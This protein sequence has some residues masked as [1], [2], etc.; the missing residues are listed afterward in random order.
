MEIRGATEQDVHAAIEGGE[1]LPARH[2]RTL[3]RRNLPFGGIWRGKR[4]D[5]KQ[6]EVY[7]V[8][9]GDTLIVITVIVKYF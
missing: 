5:T 2:G 6:L 9:E 7:T 1:R 3:Y 8:Q 4:F